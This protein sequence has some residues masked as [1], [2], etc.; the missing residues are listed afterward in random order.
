MPFSTNR[1]HETE[2]TEKRPLQAQQKAGSKSI[3]SFVHPFYLFIRKRAS[4]SASRRKARGSMSVE[5]ALIMSIFLLAVNLLFYFFHLMEFQIELQFALEQKVHEAAVRQTEIIPGR[6]QASVSRELLGEGRGLSLGGKGLRLVQN[7]GEETEFLDV[8][9]VFE[10]GPPL[11]I[12][13]PMNGTYIHRCRRRFWSGQESIQDEGAEAE[14]SEQ[15]YVYVTQSGSVYHRSRACTYLKPSVR[16][17][18][19]EGVSGLRSFRRI[20]TA[21]HRQK[22]PR[23]KM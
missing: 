8:T 15:E 16:S 23:K 1:F 7:P 13:G 17:V 14:N 6:L 22:K 21:V 9:A 11:Q 3:L 4:A 18:S 10:A 20:A 2:K 12:F 5:A 19:F